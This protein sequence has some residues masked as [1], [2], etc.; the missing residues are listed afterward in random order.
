M[1][2]NIENSL[3]H[4]LLTNEYTHLNNFGEIEI[5]KLK[6]KVII[7]VDYKNIYKE[8]IVL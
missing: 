5:N 4:R 6:N 8:S 1:A 3:G 2:S 7:I